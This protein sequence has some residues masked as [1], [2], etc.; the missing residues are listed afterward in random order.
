MNQRVNP[1]ANLDERAAPAFT[2]KPK[3]SKPVRQEVIAQIA[4]DNGFPSRQPGPSAK[5]TRR[6][7]RYPHKTGNNVQFNIKAKGTTIDRF[8]RIADEFDVVFGELL[9]LA[10]DA[11]EESR[12]R[13]SSQSDLST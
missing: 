1:F 7:Q 9:D 10:L 11:L 3:Q 5:Q 12:A 8:Y 2:T 6:R 13:G 4:D